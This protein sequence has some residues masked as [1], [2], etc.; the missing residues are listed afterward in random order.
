M[1][2]ETFKSREGMEIGVFTLENKN[3]MRVRLLSFGATI[4]EIL[5]PD[6]A[7]ALAPVALSY[8]TPQGF[9]DDRC[10]FGATV[11]R[12]ANRIARGHFEIGGAAYDVPQNEGRNHLHGGVR[13]MS[14]VLWS[15]QPMEGESV[16]FTR[17]SADGEE[18]YPGNLT[19]SVQF[20]LDEENGLWLHYTATVDKPCPVNLT[21]HVYL[22]LAGHD[23]GNVGGHW[24]RIAADG[25]TPV[26][27]EFIPTGEVASVEGTPL[28]FRNAHRIGER[29]DERFEQLK[30]A[31]GYDHNFVVNGS[32][33]RE[34][35]RVYE[36][37]SGRRMAVLTDKPCVQL[38]TG[39]MMN[40]IHGMGGVVYGRRGALCLETQFAPD[41]PNQPKFPTAILQPGQTYDYTT[42][43]RFDTADRLE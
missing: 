37:N 40:D 15:A 8:D 43:Y 35:A 32:G 14:Y 2:Q 16:R 9:V 10:Y 23:A 42:C 34:A 19:A 1:K 28:D 11:G 6:K 24:L 17:E 27:S 21:N 29:I 13:G 12:Y 39:N 3:G 26:D 7:G 36:P 20:T 31:G 5:A 38:Y 33:L 41:S 18:G 25:Y 4:A 22:N 30:L